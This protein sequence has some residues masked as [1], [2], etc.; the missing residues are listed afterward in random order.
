L[1]AVRTPA[2]LSRVPNKP[3]S[4]HR[5]VRFSD[6]DWADLDAATKDM[7]T[8]RGTILKELASWYMRR[9]G[10]RLPERPPAE[11]MTEIVREREARETAE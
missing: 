3:K 9:K 2:R 11:R 4:Q 1:K 6:D 7:G 5:S 8:D 10:A